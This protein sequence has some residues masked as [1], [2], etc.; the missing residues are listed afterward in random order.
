MGTFLFI[1]FAI[2]VVALFL[3]IFAINKNDAGIVVNT[4][5]VV[6]VPTASVSA[7]VETVTPATPTA[8]TAPTKAVVPTVNVSPTE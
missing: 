1:T 2:A 5:P 4:P 3:S 8:T 6:S 7:T